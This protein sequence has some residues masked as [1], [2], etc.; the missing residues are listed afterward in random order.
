MSNIK[1]IGMDVHKKSITVAIADEGRNGQVRSY[2]TL[3]NDPNALDKFCRKMVSTASQ[4]HF[5]YEAGPCG[6]VIYR[7]L[8][9][10]GFYCKVIALLSSSTDKPVPS[11]VASTVLRCWPVYTA[12]VS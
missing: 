5:V 10:K 4:L 9:R 1:F 12:L 6:Y 8:T 7:H 3:A 11:V 2:G